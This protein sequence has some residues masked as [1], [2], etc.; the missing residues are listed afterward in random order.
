MPDELCVEAVSLLDL[1]MTA[2][3]LHSVGT[4][5]I[6]LFKKTHNM[7]YIIRAFG[8]GGLVYREIKTS[9]RPRDMHYS[10]LDAGGDYVSSFSKL[11]ESGKVDPNDFEWMLLQETFDNVKHELDEIQASLHLIENQ[12]GD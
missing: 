7:L 8:D 2:Q 10:L 12:V 9:R 5:R 4:G 1:F 6:Y 3:T 11:V